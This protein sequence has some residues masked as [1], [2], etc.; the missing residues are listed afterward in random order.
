MASLPVSRGSI[1]T[2]PTRGSWTGVPP[3]R[4]ITKR[5]KATRFPLEQVEDAFAGIETTVPLAERVSA[6]ILGVPELHQPMGPPPG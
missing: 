5:L 3:I 4:D 2:R 6:C 1:R